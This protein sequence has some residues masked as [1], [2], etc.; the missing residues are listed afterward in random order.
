MGVREMGQ[1][2]R[3]WLGRV[4]EGPEGQVWRWDFNTEV[5]GSQRLLAVEEGRRQDGR[6]LGEEGAAGTDM[7]P[8]QTGGRYE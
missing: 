3:D 8:D 4:M 5:V 2:E 6:L 7:P 1:S